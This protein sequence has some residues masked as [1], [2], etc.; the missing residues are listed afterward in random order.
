MSGD[1]CQF[2]GVLSEEYRMDP[3]AHID[4]LNKRMNVIYDET[5]GSYLAI[6]YDAVHH[7]LTNPDV[8]STK[9]LAKRAEPVMRGKVLAQM[10]GEE[11][12]VK[13]RIIL[14]QFTGFILKNYYQP[15]LVR[16]CGSLIEKLKQRNSFDFISDF[17]SKFALLTAFNI[18]GVNDDKFDFFLEKLRV[19]VKFA[20][21]F[22]L[23]EET[24]NIA[25]SASEELEREMLE[26]INEKEYHPGNDIISFIIKENRTVKLMSDS[27][28]V[29]LSLNVLLAA[30]EPVDKVL[31]NCIYHLYR[32]RE[33]IDQLLKGTCSYNNF[34]QENLRFTPPVHLIP[35]L[36]EKDTCIDGVKLRGGEVIFSLLP[37][38][39]RDEKYF[40]VP[41]IFDP[42][43][44]FKGHLSYGAGIHSCI[45][46]QFANLQLNTALEQLVPVLS[47]Y[48]EA[49]SPKFDGIYTRGAI[50][51]HLERV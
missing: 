8:F 30:A 45:G 2:T 49:S 3:Y 20:T 41:N 31:A 15:L 51:Y 6:S 33:Y 7:V 23:S 5:L 50:E 40:D 28:I 1:N 38:A 39:N 10:E 4:T 18:V 44:S 21:G 27:E 46:A 29:A 48:K 25:L 16:L 36:I 43:R 13:R 17:G 32:K 14:R 11:H 34:L 26:L 35:R 9:P 37:S 22:N 47:E 12:R 24:K 19:I 42:H